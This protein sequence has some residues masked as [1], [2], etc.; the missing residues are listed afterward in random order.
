ME[1][2]SFLMSKDIN[3][4]FLEFIR[5]IKENSENFIDNNIENLLFFIERLKSIYKQYPKWLIL[6][7]LLKDDTQILAVGDIH[8]DLHS[9]NK[10]MELKLKNPDL[11]LIFLGD[12]VD[13][14]PYSN[15]VI[16]LA[17]LLNLLFPSSVFII[18]GN[19][20][21]YHYFEYQNP[22]FWVQFKPIR[23]LFPNLIELIEFLPVI[24]SFKD[25][26]FIHGGFFDYD[27]KNHK[28]INF[29]NRL[30]NEKGL[31]L[32]DIIEI[33]NEKIFELF[34]A[35]YAEHT[36]D[37]AFSELLGRPVK[38]L[39]NILNLE[40]NFRIKI[41]IRGH[42]PNLKGL[43]FDGRIITLI[44][45]SIYENTGKEQGELV[46]LIETKYS[47]NTKSSVKNMVIIKTIE[48]ED[49]VLKLIRL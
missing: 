2:K 12:F 42:Q 1:S 25:I 24:I 22:Q 13:R 17:L 6:D 40:K 11:V 34:W 23:N 43:S 14:G 33:E 10:I 46:T 44:T 36:K 8:G 29:V 19:H 4:F 20:E 5:S 9:L 49:L 47:G 26:L 15:E 21:V 32:K 48:I 28:D 35:D 38:Q 27:S 30:K 39:N 3:D 16:I 45:S 18:P 7:D 31:K 37:I 41:I